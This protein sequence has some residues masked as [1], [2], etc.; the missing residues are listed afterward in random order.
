MYLVGI[1]LLI[2]GIFG[3]MHFGIK[4]ETE[5]KDKNKIRTNTILA[6]IF[7]IIL[8]IGIIITG[9]NLYNNY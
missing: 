8:I 2:I 1:F 5:Y 6:I 3:F 4:V 9:N 7:I